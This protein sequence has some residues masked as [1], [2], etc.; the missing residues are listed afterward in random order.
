MDYAVFKDYSGFYDLLYSEKDYEGECDFLETVF[1][2]YADTGTILDLGCGSGNHTIRMAQRGYKVTGLDLS[3]EMLAYAKEKSREAGV[4]IAYHKG[5]MRDFSLNTQFDAVV[6]L[7][8]AFNYVTD[9][10]G[11]KQTLSTIKKHL[12]PGGLTV[13]D[14]WN[15]LAVMKILPESRFKIIE[16]DGL[17]II[18]TVTPHLDAASHVCRNH[19]RMFILENGRLVN[20]IEETHAM[21]FLFPQ[22]MAYYLTEAGF[23]VLRICVFPELD[24]DLTEDEWNMGVVARLGEP[25]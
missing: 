10:K 3:G 13:F 20:E 22:E 8:A 1:K 15:G 7:F 14:S 16:R 5:D 6:C 23:E 24:K 12:K 2:K 19:Y 9:N 18:R 4:D 11:I 25:A 17:K 21:R